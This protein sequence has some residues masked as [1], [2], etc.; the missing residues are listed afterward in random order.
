MNN[1]LFKKMEIIN[2]AN[3]IIN[4]KK[5]NDKKLFYEEYKNLINV[6][7]KEFKKDTK[8]II[9]EVFKTNTILKNLLIKY[10]IKESRKVYKT[11][12]EQYNLKYKEFI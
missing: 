5:V 9:I 4:L 10:D 1:N 2:L 11:Y 8:N 6:D 3:R 12:K 7:F